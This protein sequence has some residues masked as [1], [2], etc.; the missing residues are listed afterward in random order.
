MCDTGQRDTCNV[1]RD[2]FTETNLKLDIVDSD[3]LNSIV[4]R[5]PRDNL[6]KTR[7]GVSCRTAE[8]VTITL[9]TNHHTQPDLHKEVDEGLNLLPLPSL[10]NNSM[11]ATNVGDDDSGVRPPFV[12]ALLVNVVLSPTPSVTGGCPPATPTLAVTNSSSS[13]GQATKTQPSGGQESIL[14]CGL[15]RPWRRSAAES[16]LSRN[17]APLMAET[18]N[19]RSAGFL[20]MPTAVEYC[21][22]IHCGA[23]ASLS[24]LLGACDSGRMRS[25]LQAFQKDPSEG[26]TRHR[27]ERYFPIIITVVL[28]SLTF[29]Q[30]N[31]FG[32]PHFVWYL[33]LPPA[34]QQDCVQQREK[35][36][37]IFLKISAGI[38]S[39]PGAFPLD[40]TLVA[41][42]SSPSVGSSSNSAYTPKEG[43]TASIAGC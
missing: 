17:T 19:A 30:G 28:V 32:V 36:V 9:M 16:E 10:D 12:N 41:S 4:S 22:I 7:I 33:T 8:A 21:G 11:L 31:N 38:P 25:A 34:M 29:V 37:F 39:S 20:T 5:L 24:I 23:F 42:E 18:T 3:D 2:D 13:P 6:F 15:F 40:S 14:L 1:N 43:M 26:L 27:K 35:T